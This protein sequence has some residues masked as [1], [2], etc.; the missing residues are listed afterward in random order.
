LEAWSFSDALA[1]GT[2]VA[3]QQ[4]EPREAHLLQTGRGP[5]LSAKETG[6]RYTLARR[7]ARA[8]GQR[9][10]YILAGAGFAAGIGAAGGAVF[11][12]L[13]GLLFGLLHGMMWESLATAVGFPLLCG[14]YFGAGGAVAGLLTGGFCRIID[15]GP[16]DDTPPPA[17]SAPNKG[18]DA[19]D[20]RSPEDPP[21]PGPGNGPGGGMLRR[22]TKPKDS[23]SRS[24]EP[25][26]HHALV[27][28]SLYR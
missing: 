6:M 11:G 20:Q 28:N 21:E 9:M 8:I 12:I 16:I 5:D 13:W 22:Q 23:A 27:G 10:V 26:V 2:S 14:A 25:I 7:I 18:A 4:A 17:K 1:N 19:G 15:G 24:A 3:I